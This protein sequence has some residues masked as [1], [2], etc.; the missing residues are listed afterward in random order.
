M[1]TVDHFGKQLLSREPSLSAS[2]ATP[3]GRWRWMPPR[4]TQRTSKRISSYQSATWLSTNNSIADDDCGLKTA[5]N[6]GHRVAT[7]A[8]RLHGK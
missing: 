2:R 3:F 4:H 1:Q 8:L 5:K 7:V 6:L